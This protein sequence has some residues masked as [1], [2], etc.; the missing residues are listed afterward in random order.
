MFRCIQCSNR[1]FLPML[2]LDR[3]EGSS[4][5]VCFVLLFGDDVGWS[6]CSISEMQL[7]ESQLGGGESVCRCY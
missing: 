6:C 5:P 3:F 4:C 7:M 2:T 1:G